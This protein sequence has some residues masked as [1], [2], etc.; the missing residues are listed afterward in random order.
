MKGKKRILRLVSCFLT[1]VLSLALVLP[2]N[3]V[4]IYENDGNSYDEGYI[5]LGESHV[6]IMARAMGG[7]TDAQGNV[8]GMDGVRYHYCADQS[9][10]TDPYG[11]PNTFTMSGNLFF[12]YEG[13]GEPED[14]KTQTGKEYIYSDGKGNKGRGVE[15]I[16]EIINGNPNIAHWNIISYQGAAAVFS[17]NADIGSYYV[18][19]YQNWIDYEFPEADCY[20]LSM[21]TMTKCYRRVK[22]KDD[23]N[24]ALEKSFP[25]Q[26][27]NYMD[28]FSARYPQGM[29]DPAEKTDTLHW[30]NTTYIELTTDVIQKIQQK[31]G[32]NVQ[33]NTIAKHDVI[34][35][36][37][38]RYTNNLTVV[39]MQPELGEAVQLMP[40]LEA[41]APM[42]ETGLP[43]QV[44]DV[45][46]NGFYQIVLDGATYYVPEIGL[47]N[48]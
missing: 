39:Y 2:V 17:A 34:R 25:Q 28:F 20:F 33:Q 30:N 16:H 24:D 22:F 41:C 35:K 37:E 44:T 23:I 36:E 48:P 8:I 19:S 21:S 18:K 15:K 45:T 5:F 14:G 32:I 46:D 26:Y 11:N 12:V 43:I 10:S 7:F 38:I 47:S 31:R 40:V 42:F 3:A 27:L 29:F 4:T 9:M 1:L 13:W 6:F